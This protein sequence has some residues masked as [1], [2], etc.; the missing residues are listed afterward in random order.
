[1]VHCCQAAQCHY[2]EDSNLKY[3]CHHYQRVW[4][5]TA[6]LLSHGFSVSNHCKCTIFSFF[7][8]VV[9]VVVV[10]TPSSLSRLLVIL[11]QD[12]LVNF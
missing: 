1:M 4:L 10:V 7:L 5:N 3:Q 11:Y 2:S 6:V 9:V 12:F 8:L